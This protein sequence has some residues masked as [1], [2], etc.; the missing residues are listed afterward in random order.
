MNINL[1]KS[2]I[3]A[4]L[5]ALGDAP[6]A[7]STDWWNPTPED[8]VA[9]CTK[10]GF[11]PALAAGYPGE[12]TVNAK[13]TYQKKIAPL[14]A[15]ASDSAIKEYAGM[16]FTRDGRRACWTAFM[17]ADARAK[18]GLIGLAGSPSEADKIAQGAG[19][20]DP[21]ITRILLM[22]Y[23]AVVQAFYG[24]LVTNQSV[25]NAAN[26]CVGTAMSSA[27]GA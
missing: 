4:A 1:A 27:S 22:G 19:N 21:E 17:L 23:A 9:F 3:Q 20:M 7:T 16:G 2:Q 11:D 18:C 15:D 13:D 24:P 6:T 26:Y 8:Q 12:P 14:A 5:A 10:Y 25:S